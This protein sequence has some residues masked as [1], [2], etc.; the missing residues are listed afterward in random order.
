M[1]VK[2]Y[3]ELFWGG[4]WSISLSHRITYLLWG[5]K[6]KTCPQGHVSSSSLQT[7]LSECW[8]CLLVWLAL[9]LLTPPAWCA[10]EEDSSIS[11]CRKKAPI[12]SQMRTTCKHRTLRSPSALTTHIQERFN[13]NLTLIPNEPGTS[14]GDSGARVFPQTVQFWV[15]ISE[16]TNTRLK[17]EGPKARPSKIQKTLS[18]T[19]PTIM[20][21]GASWAFI[22]FLYTKTHSTWGNGE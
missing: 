9:H 7:G 1:H 21:S 13:V 2:A 15:S 3:K 4:E 20:W 22:I 5:N 12:C 11:W 17:K 18:R 10:F 19:F 14:A 6:S 16:Q 8:G